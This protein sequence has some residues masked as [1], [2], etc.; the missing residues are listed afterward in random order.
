MLISIF[1]VLIISCW[2]LTYFFYKAIC[3]FR[4]FGNSFFCKFLNNIFSENSFYSWKT[5]VTGF[6]LGKVSKWGLQFYLNLCMTISLKHHSTYINYFKGWVTYRLSHAM[7]HN[8]PNN[9]SPQPLLYALFPD[10]RQIDSFFKSISNKIT[11]LK[12]R[13]IYV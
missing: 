5:L 4:K 2:E 6:A 11:S 12:N 8:D 10:F 13:L 9:M 3:C 1:I 7:R